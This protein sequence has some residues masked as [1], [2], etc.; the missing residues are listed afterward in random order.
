MQR[1]IVGLFLFYSFSLYAQ[2]GTFRGSIYDGETGESL[3]GVTVLITNTSIGTS[4]DLDGMFSVDIPQGTYQINISYISY[5]S[6][7]ISDVK[8][9]AGETTVIDNI[10]LYSSAFELEEVVVTADAV[11]R[12]E[13][14]LQSMKRKSPAILDGISAAKMEL[15]GDATAVEAAKRVTGVSIEGGK[16]VYVRGLGDRYTKTTLNMMDIP[17]LDPDKN[18][19]QMDIFPTNLINNIVVS[20]NFTA[21]MPADFTGGLLNIETKDFPQKKFLDISIGTSFNPDM[22]FNSNYITYSGSP[23][24][25]LGF[26]NGTRALPQYANSSN[27][28]TPISGHGQDAARDFILSFNPELGASQQTSLIDFSAGISMGNQIDL[29]NNSD[30]EPKLAYVLSLSYKSD[31][32]YYDSVTYSEYQRYIDPEKDELRYATIQTGQVG[33]HNVLIG[34]LAGLAYKTKNSKYRLMFMMLQNGESRAGQFSIIN[35]GQAVG[36]S[37]YYATSD[38]L[39]Y[40]QRG[41]KNLLIHGKHLFRGRNWELDWRVSPT[42]STSNDPD[43]RKTAFT[44]SVNGSSFSAGAGGNPARIWRNLLEINNTSKLDL[45]KK[46]LFNN[47]DANLKLGAVHNYKYRDYEI[48]FFDIQFFGSQLWDEADPNLVL[49]PENIYP[50]RP[51]SI[52]YQSGNNTPN[53][54]AY[55]SNVNNFGAYVSNEAYLFDSFKTILGLRVEKYIMRHTGRDQQYASGDTVNGRNLD[56]DIMLDSFD[57]FPTANLIYELTANQNLRASYSK[58]IARPSFK[59]L[60]FAQILDPISNRIF[61]GSLFPYSDWDGKLTETRID[62]IDLRWELFMKADEL[63]SVSTFYKHFNNPIELVRIP[64]QQTSTEY[65]PRNVGEGQLY[66]IEME[67]RKNM[68]F[69]FDALKNLDMSINV[70]LVESMIDMTDAEYRSR[71]SYERIGETIDKTRQM[72]GQSP[73][74]INAGLTYT[75]FET[76]LSAGTFYNVKGSTLHIV[77]AGLF[78]D[79]YAEPFHSLNISLNKKLGKNDNAMLEMKLSNLLNSRIETYYKSFNATPMVYSSLSPGRAISIGFKYQF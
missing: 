2:N 51:N 49:L 46:Y 56:N 45:T 13:A 3:V 20:K 18:S 78:P 61:N 77:G 50:N 70:T 48:L 73:Y 40:N 64:E 71:K 34:G 29:N 32:K 33:E 15:T 53:P 57:F 72:A 67:I 17:G 5:Q 79:I 43:L 44:H 25:F 74:L 9:R 36:Q 59:E 8:I 60:S 21:D 31:T 75:N 62:N 6:K 42:M 52:Y 41:L 19:L 23:T 30:K 58:T 37:G 10:K 11:R 4:T 65:Q 16:Y 63:I 22:H 7:R 55:S 24:D 47:R 26:D 27:I 35:D 68:G 1:L 54:N 69:I 14:A 12:T 38:N 66:G 28:P 76:G 39:E